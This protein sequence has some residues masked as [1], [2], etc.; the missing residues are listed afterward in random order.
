MNEKVLKENDAHYLVGKSMGDLMYAEQ[1][2]TLNTF[3]FNKLPVRE[4][5][6][7]HIDEFTLGQ[8]MMYFMVETITACHLIS[9][10]PFNQPAV[11]QG[12]KLTKDYLSKINYY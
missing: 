3:I 8:L 11:E 2:A 12:K 10:N 7:K 4:F 1:K 9:V 6:C 5:F